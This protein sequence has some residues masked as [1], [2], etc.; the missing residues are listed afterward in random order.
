MYVGMRADDI[1][2]Y[3]YEASRLKLFYHESTEQLP[4]LH[5][6]I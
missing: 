2:P 3:G 5:N 1:R 6:I 4:I